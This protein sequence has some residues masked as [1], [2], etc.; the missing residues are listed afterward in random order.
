MP[1]TSLVHDKLTPDH[2]TAPMPRRRFVRRLDWGAL[3]A[4][5][6]HNRQPWIADLREP[7][8]IHLVCDG[9]HLPPEADPYGRQI[10]IGCGAFLELA[11][12][13]GAQ[14]GRRVDVRPLPDGAPA[15]TALPRGTRVA[16]LTLAAQGSAAPDRLYPNSR[17]D[18]PPR[19]STRAPA[20][21]LTG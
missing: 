12:I 18:T 10:L 14:R 1:I 7:G 11:V 13:A 3:L 5:D 19:L 9:E 15:C 8:V 6:P 4:P 17:A 20:R 2:A 16:T 21:C